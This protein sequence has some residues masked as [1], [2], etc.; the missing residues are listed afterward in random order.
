MPVLRPQL[1]Q[2]SL[3]EL[4]FSREVHL[5]ILSLSIEV[6]PQEV[7][8]PSIQEEISEEDPLE[9]VEEEEVQPTSVLVVRSVE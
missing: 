3:V 7:E 6:A 8:V 2:L 4:T 5:L 1:W 9:V